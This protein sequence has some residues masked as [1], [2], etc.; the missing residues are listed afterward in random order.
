MKTFSTCVVI[1]INALVLSAQ[2]GSDAIVFRHANVVDG[3]SRKPLMNVTV[4]IGK[5]KIIS[6]QKGQPAVPSGAEVIDLKGKWLVPGYIDAHVHLFDF[7]SGRRALRFG[8]TTVRTMQ[9]DHFIDI[10]IRDAHR[11]GQADLPDVVA[12]GYQIRPDM[13]EAFFQDF[14]ELNDL[15][16]RL[17]GTDNVR[18]V[19]RALISRNVDHIK[20]LATE[21]AGT[22]D[23][24]PRKRTFTD[25]E[26]KAIVDEAGKAGLKVAA[27]AHGD[28][29][30][31]AAVRAGVWSIEHGTWL[32]DQTLRLMRSRGTWFVTN[33]T[34]ARASIYWEEISSPD[35]FLVERRRTMRPLAKQVTRRAYAIGVPL[36]AASDFTYGPLFDYGRLTIADNA[37]GLVEAGLPRMEAIKAI[38]SRAATALRI[39]DRTGVIRKG[40]EAD[41]LVLGGNP[42]SSIDALKDIRMIVNDGRVV[43]RSAA[44]FGSAS[45]RTNP[46]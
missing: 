5:G 14:P 32:S 41:V 15:K 19:V 3:V 24:D 38:T 39:Q 46:D 17:S 10:A 4:T 36:A 9:C 43:F 30:A 27:H 34:G 2:T 6:V 25:E 42:L 29:G 44:K 13:F 35:P 37:A 23:T 16:P 33:I 45:S 21:R 11:K 28:D 22:P 20:I 31:A 18:R 8:I 26:L 1:F 12:A 7:E 40:L